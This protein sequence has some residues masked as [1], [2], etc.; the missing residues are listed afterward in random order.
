LCSD[1]GNYNGQAALSL[2]KAIARC[3]EGGEHDIRLA[4]NS[5]FDGTIE[6]IR[7][8]F[9]DAIPP[10]RIHVFEVP[11]PVAERN[12]A[13]A[14]RSRAAE[15]V[16][17]H[18]LAS[19]QPDIVLIPDLFHGL[20]DE[21]VTPPEQSD[22]RFDTVVALFEID[23][24]R[25]ID[26]DTGDP[27]AR[28]WR[29]RK[30]H[31]LRH[32]AR[33]LTLSGE[34]RNQVQAL[35]GV[36]AERVVDLGMVF[37]AGG[38]APSDPTRLGEDAGAIRLLE[39]LHDLHRSRTLAQATSPMTPAK[40]PRLAYVSPL[41]PEQTGIAD[42]SAELLPALAQY[43]DIEVVTTQAMVADTAAD[44][45]LRTPDWFA[46]HAEQFDRIVYHFGNSQ[47]H[48]HM[49]D[50]L[51]RHPGVV[52]LHDFF[53]GGAQYC[54][55]ASGTAPGAVVRA[56]YESHGYQGLIEERRD[57]AAVLWDYPCNKA[58]LDQAD[59]IIVHS[60]FSRSLAE[61]WHG[62]GASQDWKAIPLP[63]AMPQP[64]SRSEARARIMYAECDFLVCSFGMLGPSKSNM[65]LLE[66]WLETPLAQDPG[67]QLLFVGANDEGDYGRDLL[68][69][70]A[71]SGCPDR[72]RITGY[73]SPE[74]YHAYLAA[75][76]V[77][78]QLRSLSRGE[79]SAAILDCLAHGVA[80][81]VNANGAANE[82]PDDVLH[83]LPDRFSRMELSAALTLLHA[84]TAGV[85][86]LG[87]RAAAY[88]QTMRQP[89]TVA[90]MYFEAIEDFSRKSA[91]AAYR[92]LIGTLAELPVR[93]LPQRRDLQETARSIA[94]NRP[95]RGLR[96]LLVDVS[97]IVQLDY[98]TG[99]QRVVRS[100]LTVLINKPPA[101]YR[102]EP[103][104]STGHHYM[105]A[106]KFTLNLIDVPD[107]GVDDAPIETAPGDMFLG[108]D[109][110][111]HGVTL[112]HR[113][114]LNLHE[115]G[116]TVYFV[117]YDILP[118]LLPDAF[119][120]CTDAYHSNW[121][122]TISAVA[123][124]LICI[125]RAVADELADWLEKNAP[126]RH[127][128]LQIGYFHL[129]ADIVASIP[130]T[131]LT[132]NAAQIERQMQSAPT[133]LMV[134]TLEPRKGH[135]LALSAFELLWAEGIAVNL[136]IVG[137]N[138]WMVHSLAQRL[139]QHAENGKRLFW[140]D[141]ASDEMLMRLYEN[142]SALLAASEGEGFGLP[143]IEAAQHRLPIIAR[144]LPVFRE[145]A[146]QHAFYFSGDTPDALAAALKSW[147]QLHRSG[148]APVSTGMQWFTWEESAMQLLEVAQNKRW[149][150]HCAA[151]QAH[152]DQSP[153][154]QLLV[155]VSS[156]ACVDLKTGIERM[157]RAQLQALMRNPPAGYRVEPVDL[158][159][160]GGKWHS[161]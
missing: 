139:D 69:A 29:R 74:M 80:T 19:L 66:A 43:Y 7:A 160:A 21:G 5:R 67:C 155:D 133:I 101:G 137:K 49:F 83:K 40:R 149:Y 76:D 27:V 85:R 64:L 6:A 148:T 144:D 98:K 1:N 71:A 142:A 135:A 28:E 48:V 22:A 25:R 14:W 147:L 146:E 121:L 90:R 38:D 158:T 106:R 95:R 143:L 130:T 8:A 68:D 86:R 153:Q 55:E 111:S 128:D 100:I 24:L 105:Y 12:P 110:F 2:A 122:K 96:Q 123:D 152:E 46:Q 41:P 26:E 103:V 112:N 51:Q 53:L 30:L 65:Q 13:N 56:L 32:A 73:T 75:S 154:H 39:A 161:R 99:I 33:I 16:R 126:P 18:F 45:P 82:L 61:S 31:T 151:K 109:F 119:S 35:L 89:G 42:Y 114:F 58:V 156:I 62:P 34:H 81:I 44:F 84:D 129:G 141:D 77:G 92:R 131:G 132:A 63:R 4:L 17:E 127:T 117:V 59:G 57:R 10:E 107:F 79:T 125:S 145:V 9:A 118:I 11:G 94:A 134:G 37:E 20:D 116:V 97:A 157:V 102:V 54:L 150:R 93:T 108:L 91:S 140:L 3:N 120:E 78:V 70:I 124:G 88:I 72:I 104:Y 47:F 50:L 15:Q 136:V 36:T 159:D 138:G 23:S 87:E 52:V 113:R 60:Q 115:R